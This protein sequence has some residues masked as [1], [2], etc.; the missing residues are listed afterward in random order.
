MST[1]SAVQETHT[2]SEENLR[3]RGTLHGY[4]FIAAAFTASQH[5]FS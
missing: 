5:T 4:V 2:E 1:F 3:S